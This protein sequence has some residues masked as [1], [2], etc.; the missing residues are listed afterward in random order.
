MRRQETS[1][2]V[3]QAFKK[4][5]LPAMRRQ[6]APVRVDQTCKNKRRH[7]CNEEAGSSSEGGINLQ[8]KTTYCTCY[9]E[10][11]GTNKDGP[12]LQEEKTTYLQ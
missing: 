10:A 6:E 8:G 7:T 9:D 3:D 4:R 5:R 1:V 2:R 11:G 12:D